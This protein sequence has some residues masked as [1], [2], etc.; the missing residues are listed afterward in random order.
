[1]R[2]IA[3]LAIVYLVVGS[4]FFVNNYPPQSS[5]VAPAKIIVTTSFYPLYFFTSQIAGNL[6]DVINITPSG[7]E[8]HDF[9][10]SPSDAASIAHSQL[11]VLNGVG[12]EPWGD[13][14]HPQ[15][16]LVVAHD[17]STN[18]NPHTWLDPVLAAIEVKKI[19]SALITID[20]QHQATYQANQQKL[21]QA[22]SQID[23]EYKTGLSNCDHRE[24]VTS[25]AAFSYL[26]SRYHLQ[27]IA[28]SGLS[29]DEEPTAQQLAKVV[30]TTRRQ[31]INVIFFESLVSP[32]LAQTIAAETGATTLVLDPIEGIPQDKE[33]AGENYLTLMRQNL[34]NLRIALQCQ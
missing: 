15:H 11:L 5:R 16:T 24:F 1:M 33:V 18:N 14:V 25:H 13:K 30:E 6:A 29:P 21:M 3:F 20:P 9:E 26:A 34:T 32:K 17:L 7:S 12:L 27:Q 19:T 31:N 8:P 4:L 22:L 2:L 23:E 28:I 10:P